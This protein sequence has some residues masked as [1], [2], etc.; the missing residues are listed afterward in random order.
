MFLRRRSRC[1]CI[2]TTAHCLQ[3]KLP[4]FLCRWRS[5]A[6]VERACCCVGTEHPLS[7][8]VLTQLVA[9][10]S[11]SYRFKVR[12]YG[13]GAI[14]AALVLLLLLARCVVAKSL[15]LHRSADATDAASSKRRTNRRS[16]P[17]AS[18]TSALACRSAAAVSLLPCCSTHRLR[19]VVSLSSIGTSARAS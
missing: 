2:L 18:L 7:T 4:A 6:I 8:S 1:R 13:V 15:R 17:V 12:A 16:S 19:F 9:R 3:S 14:V 10:Q 11:Q 5:F